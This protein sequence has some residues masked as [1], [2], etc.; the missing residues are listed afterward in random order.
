MN[1]LRIGIIGTGRMAEARFRSLLQM[2]DVEIVWICSRE[3]HKAEKLLDRCEPQNGWK[4]RPLPLTSWKNA[5]TRGDTQAVVITSPNALHH[6]MA[7]EALGAGKQVL[8]EYPAA[9]SV[10]DGLDLVR[11]A[12]DASAVLHIGLTH[13]YGALHKKLV[14]I[15]RGRS[16][17]ELGLPRACQ[18]TLCTGNPIGRFYDKDELSGGMIIGSLYHFIDEVLDLFGDVTSIKAD[19]Q[20]TRKTTGG[21]A[22]DSGAL[23]LRTKEGCLIQMLYSRG[24]VKPGLGYKRVVIFDNGYLEQ[25]AGKT[26]LLTPEGAI[27]IAPPETDSLYADTRHFVESVFS[28]GLINDTAIVAQRALQLAEEAQ[29]QIQS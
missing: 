22:R 5:S 3:A 29:K 18:M 10:A 28:Q 7:C 2:S 26:K 21:I 15:C 8:L 23:M 11:R 6:Q 4:S 9:T 13:R 14:G 17:P 16:R 1:P 19:Y 20:S 25:Q 24:F 12:A 27:E